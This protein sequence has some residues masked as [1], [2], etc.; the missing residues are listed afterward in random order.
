MYVT[1]GSSSA[2]NKSNETDNSHVNCDKNCNDIDQNNYAI[3]N[4]DNIEINDQYHENQTVVNNLS[5]NILRK[6]SSFNPKQYKYHQ[7]M[8]KRFIDK[9]L[10]EEKSERLTVGRLNIVQ[11]N[12]RSALKKLEK[13]ESLADQV[14]CHVLCVSETWFASDLEY[15][16]VNYENLT[17]AYSHKKNYAGGVSIFVRRDIVSYFRVIDLKNQMKSKLG[18]IVGITSDKLALKIYC[19]Y[20]ST[21]MTSKNEVAE[22]LKDI[23]SLNLDDT[24]NWIFTGDVNMPTAYGIN[25]KNNC[26][27][28]YR[29]I[30]DHFNS[31]GSEQLIEEATHVKGNTLDVFLCSPMINTLHSKVMSHTD[32]RSDHYPI[33]MMMELEHGM[34]KSS[35]VLKIKIIDK[36]RED[37]Q[38]YKREMRDKREELLKIVNQST[39]NGTDLDVDLAALNLNEKIIEIWNKHV[40]TKWVYPKN[41]A[42]G[43]EVQEQIK[44]LKEVNKQYHKRSSEVRSESK[45]LTKLLEIDKRNKAKERLDKIVED[46]DFLFKFFNDARSGEKRVG[47]FFNSTTGKLTESAQ[48]IADLCQTQYVGTW[49]KDGKITVDPDSPPSWWEPGMEELDYGAEITVSASQVRRAIFRVRRKVGHGPCGVTGHMLKEAVDELVDPLHMMFNNMVYKGVWPKCY[50]QADVIP[51]NKPGGRKDSV[52]NTRPISLTSLIGKVFETLLA[53]NFI[54]HL[55][56]F[57][58]GKYD[59]RKNQFGFYAG[60]SVN[61]NLMSTLHRAYTILDQKGHTCEI[62]YFDLSR[63]FDRLHFNTFIKDLKEVGVVGKHLRL[64]ISWLMDRSQ[65]VKIGSAYSE[66]ATLSSSCCQ[67]STLGPLC[68]IQYMNGCIPHEKGVRGKF[69]YQ[70]TYEE[71]YLETQPEKLK[72]LTN[73]IYYSIYADDSKILASSHLHEE[74]QS[75]INRFVGCVE[76]IQMKIN[77]KKSF[78]LYLGNNQPLHDYYVGDHKLEKKFDARDLGLTFGW[79][80]RKI[81][82]DS[83]IKYRMSKCNQLLRISRSIVSVSDGSLATHIKIWQTYLFPQLLT[84]SEFFFF[85]TKKECKAID[86]VYR[87]YFSNISFSVYDVETFPHPP[88]VMLKKLHRIRFWRVAQG[89]TGVDPLDVFTFLGNIDMRIKRRVIS[90]TYCNTKGFPKINFAY[91]H[92]HWYNTLPKCIGRSWEKFCE[93]INDPNYISV[94]LYDDNAKQIRSDI[95]NGKRANV[96]QRRLMHIQESYDR[97]NEQYQEYIESLSQRHNDFY[98]DDEDFPNID[99]VAV[100]DMDID[101][102]GASIAE[103]GSKQQQTVS[104][105]VS[106]PLPAAASEVTRATNFYEKLK[107]F[108]D[109]S[110]P[111]TKIEEDAISKRQEEEPTLVAGEIAPAQNQ[112]RRY[113]RPSEK[114]GAYQAPRSYFED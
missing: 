113:A 109:L 10:N 105:R 23:K 37:R 56:S 22:Y 32:W 89:M 99:G 70:N 27:N 106:S 63:A 75:E 14:E 46:S 61:D 29:S 28:V 38:G 4:E 12:S 52:E 5:N 35:E 50:K 103:T 112:R 104:C 48:E 91:R 101:I 71:R 39:S 30:Y 54:K 96:R 95:L 77:I 93:H 81:C 90:A 25:K 97:A 69:K 21:D 11:I 17:S 86:D 55:K 45:K 19:T 82:F 34:K 98:M 49:N 74:L 36:E 111:L 51:I 79:A 2:V 83:T 18:Q 53:W 40:K 73:D 7:K 64:W 44:V 15:K 114:N 8:K 41:E 92:V 87:D 80:N 6:K 72:R 68:Y 33:H 59:I 62:I 31:I 100:N 26:N 108:E 16:L 88:S 84:Y 13:L 3:I 76:G 110:L 67:G 47:P 9:R 42:Y 24:E 57:K 58:N 20:R 94:H 43:V 102:G 78:V 65:R 85:E 107:F 60:R 66:S 1:T